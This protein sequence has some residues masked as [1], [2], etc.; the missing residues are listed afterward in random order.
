MVDQSKLERSQDMLRLASEMSL[1]YYKKP[2]IITYSG[3]KDSDVM[4]DLARKALK[5]GEFEVVN[6]HTTVDAPPT[7]YHI[8]EVFEQLKADGI[9]TTVKYPMHKGKR[10]TMWDLIADNGMPPTR[11]ARYC[12]T[13][14]KENSTSNSLRAVGVRNDESRTRSS[15]DDFALWGGTRTNYS[16]EHVKE[17]Y[18]EAQ[19]KDEFWDCQF[20]TMAKKNKSI[21]VRPILHWTHNDIWDYIHENDIKYNPLYDKGFKRVG[22]I[23]CPLSGCKNMKRGFSMFPTYRKAYLRAFDK[24]IKQHTH[25]CKWKTAEEVMEWW[26]ADKTA[27]PGQLQLSFEEQTDDI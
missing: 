16:V 11:L 27:I 19:E 23:G 2:L 10:V 18:A 22:C 25:G 15:Y 4:L 12:C 5:P 13:V 6:S 24:M 1:Q 20:I 9:K 8:R 14:L 7:V 21:V 17:V 3:G 26:L